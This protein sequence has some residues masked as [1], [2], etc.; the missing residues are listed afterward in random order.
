M[1]KRHDRQHL[2]GTSAM[3]TLAFAAAL[4]MPVAASAAAPSV[5]PL[6]LRPGVTAVGETAAAKQISVALV[7]PSRDPGGAAAFATHVSTPGDALY[8]QY[9]KPGEFAARFGATE[10]NYAAVRA[11]AVSQGL[12]VGEAYTA[13]TILPVSGSAA[14]L[15]AAF[16]VKFSDFRDAQGRVFYA[17]DGEAKLPP[18]ISSL[19]DSVVGLSS[20]A[21]FLP[22]ARLKPPTA[23][24]LESGTGP[25][26]AFLAA[27]LRAAYNVPPQPFTTKTQTLAVF[28]QGGFDPGDIATYEARNKLPAVPVKVRGV[29]GYGGGIDDPGVEIEAVI[30]LDMQIGLN[31]AAKQI[32]VYEDGTDTFQVALL[33]SLSAMATDNKATSIS[34]SY[35]QDEAFQGIAAIR[36]ENTVLLQMAAQGQA[37]FVSSGDNGAYGDGALPLNVSDPASQPKVTAV[38]G[39]TLFTG[40]KE[41]YFAEEAWNDLS[42]GAGATGGGVS[43][44]WKIPFYQSHQGNPVATANGGSATY[45]NVPDVAAVGNPLTGIAIYSKMNGGWLTYGGTSVSA[46]IWAGFYS[47]ANAASEGLGFAP[48]GFANPAIYKVATTFGLFYPDFYDVADGS[49]GDPTVFGIPGFQA[50]FGYDNTTGWGSF[51]GENLLAEFALLPVRADK[52][53]PPAVKD[54]TASETTTTV[55]LSWKPA[56]G[57]SGYLILGFNYNTF[58]TVTTLLQKGTSATVTGLKAG[59]TYEFEVLSISPGGYKPAAPII[60]ATPSSSG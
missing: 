42:A 47:L 13:R 6:V 52:N 17:A 14:A 46:P 10:A 44:V 23:A 12:T 3:R 8:R 38:G 30:D 25:G 57:V 36:A 16:G 55:S 41:E 59:T 58:A 5:S 51:N 54:L 39:T 29:N 11:W 20:E 24:P 35:G 27:D 9:L 56:A 21:H 18:G 37:V 49:N 4:A 1:T 40:P 22:L 45:R 48:A 33:D 32:L 31:P 7:L 50:G 15:G 2:R 34:I 53:P 43:T 19:V 60:V 28:E 26:A